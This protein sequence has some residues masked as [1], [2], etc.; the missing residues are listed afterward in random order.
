MLASA[1]GI[2]GLYDERFK[3]P[4]LFLGPNIPSNKIIKQQASSI[5][6]F[7]TILDLIKL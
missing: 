6:I 3:I 4:L 5:D 7:P 1:K 2:T